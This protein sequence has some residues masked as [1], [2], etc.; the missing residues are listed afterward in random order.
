MNSPDFLQL[1]VAAALI[2]TLTGYLAKGRGRDPIKWF[3]IGMLC[4]I[5]ALIA[6]YLFPVVE[7]K[8]VT[9]TLP[10]IAP[11][12]VEDELSAK[13]WFYLDE[14]HVRYGPEPLDTLKLRFKDGDITKRTYVWTDGMEGWKRLEE[15]PDI[16]ESMSSDGL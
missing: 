15:L 5:F 12:P 10:P 11:K 6:L 13:P 14:K 16:L 8:E 7:Q 4:G 3:L 9:Q 1:L 2:G